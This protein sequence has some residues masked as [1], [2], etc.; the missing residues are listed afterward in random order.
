MVNPR[1][2]QLQPR[3]NV[4]QPEK[5]VYF[6][7][8]APDNQ[9]YSPYNTPDSNSA[10]EGKTGGGVTHRV[11]E[12]SLLTNLLGSQGTS[13][14]SQWRYHQPVYC[15]TYTETVRPTTP[16]LM[17][18][19]LRSIYRGRSTSYSVNYGGQLLYH[20]GGWRELEYDVPISTDEQDNIVLEFAPFLWWSYTEVSPPDNAYW[21]TTVVLDARCNSYQ[22]IPVLIRGAYFIQVIKRDITG[23]I[24]WQKNYGEG[25]MSISAPFYG[26]TFEAAFDIINDILYITASVADGVVLL[27]LTSSGSVRFSKIIFNL[28]TGFDGIYTIYSLNISP[29]TSYITMAGSLR[30]LILGYFR[31]FGVIITYDKDGNLLTNLTKLSDAISP[32][33]GRD[34]SNQIEGINFDSSGNMYLAMRYRSRDDFWNDFTERQAVLVGTVSMSGS[35]GPI[36]MIGNFFQVGAPGADQLNLARDNTLYTT[37][38]DSLYILCS[39]PSGLLRLL[40]INKNTL[41]L[42]QVYLFASNTSEYWGKTRVRDNLTYIFTT[43]AEGARGRMFAVEGSQIKLKTLLNTDGFQGFMT[44]AQ[45]SDNFNYA[46]GATN[47]GNPSTRPDF[48]CVGFNPFSSGTVAV[49]S[50]GYTYGVTYTGPPS[51]PTTM[52][53][54]SLLYTS[55]TPFTMISPGSTHPDGWDFDFSQ[56]DFNC[57]V[58]DT[59]SPVWVRVSTS[60]TYDPNP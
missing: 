39:F 18:S 24:I 37:N 3:G 21:K 52:S 4:T 49:S 33:G 34:F 50:S 2:S 15:T 10:A 8:A 11:N 47:V 48:S 5:Y 31:N 20:P 17:S 13:D 28:A 32:Y 1:Q 7:G 38:T 46:V 54:G 27:S 55:G 41:N 19:P 22:C 36:K 60:G 56:A 6:G 42:E 23:I 29:V 51:I 12:S 45:I 9:D 40:Y 59:I 30:G 44:G 58:G 25:V 16:G 35:V 26:L 57:S 43:G 14:R 53:T